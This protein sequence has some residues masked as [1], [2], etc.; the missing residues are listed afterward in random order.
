VQASNFLTVGTPDANGG[1]ANATGFLLFKVKTTFPEDV[2]IS[3]NIT[4]V[5]CLPATDAGVCNQPNGT[6]GSDYSGQLQANATIRI[7]DHYNGPGANE[8]ATVVDLPFPVNLT[9][10][11]TTDTST[12][13]TCD[14]TT[15]GA[16]VCPECGVRQGERTVVEM[17][18]VQVFDGGADGQ[19]ATNDNTLFMDQGVFI[20]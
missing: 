6:D 20:P 17:A 10:A 19:V 15:S 4:D 12:G 13:G 11:N 18:Q 8:P 5:H 16:V 1:P 2:L 7:T 3:G 9:C 14:V